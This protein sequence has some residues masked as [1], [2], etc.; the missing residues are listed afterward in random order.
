MRPV[1][2]AIV[3]TGYW[4]VSH[5]RTFAAEPRAEVTWVCDRNSR[6]LHRAA[7]LAPRARATTSFEDLLS[8]PDIEAVVLAT[9]AVT[10]AEMAIA[11]L[12]RGLHVLVEK[13]L[14]LSVSSAEAV[15]RSAERAGTVVLVGHLMLY[16][17]AVEYL[18]RLVESG[19][20]GEIFYISS[21]RANLGRLRSDENALWSFG[22][23][24]LSMIDYLVP[25]EPRTIAARG[26]SY[27]QPGIADVVFVN[28]ELQR[29][30]P[31]AR[32]I[33]AQVHLSWLNPRKER[34][35]T[36]VGSRK[37]VEFDDCAADK[38]QIFDRGYDRPPEFTNFAEYLTIRNGDVLIPQI[39]MEE[40]LAEEARHF[41][42]CIVTCA[43]PRTPL[44]SGL[45]TVALL[46]AAQ[47][48]LER[49]GDPVEIPHV[50]PV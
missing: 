14:A 26:A 50:L 34:R 28:L 12:E 36:I 40:P 27:L 29:P 30:S 35:L 4:G 3:G 32:P 49:G 23:H 33:M 48:S 42:D 6:A 46:S 17:P 1:R 20:L 38:L 9:P 10:H 44:G 47:T 31:S 43:T 11:C 25:V 41:L 2:V 13:P 19:E 16:H 24:D 8:S 39:P 18:R 22:P 15:A 21:V 7:A 45:R 5:V 37:M